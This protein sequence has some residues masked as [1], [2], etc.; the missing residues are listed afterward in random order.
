MITIAGG[1][2]T[3]YRLMAKRAV[4]LIFSKESCKTQKSPLRVILNP[5]LNHT[6]ILSSICVQTIKSM[7]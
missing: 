7:I 4:D 1:K 5:N 6:M 2:L 3:G